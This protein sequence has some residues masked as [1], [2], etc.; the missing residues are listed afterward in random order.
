MADEAIPFTG[1]P[2]L[3]ALG[4]DQGE[5][6]ERI[7]ELGVAV[8]ALLGLD[9]DVMVDEIRFQNGGLAISGLNGEDDHSLWI[10]GEYRAGLPGH[11]WGRWVL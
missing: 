3:A 2:V 6:R 1:V 9:P 5:V 4:G 7:R 8:L 11:F 10:Y